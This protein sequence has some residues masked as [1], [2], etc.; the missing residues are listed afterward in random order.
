MVA[1]DPDVGV[2]AI[3]LAQSW[4][5][6]IDARACGVAGVE[7]PGPGVFLPLEVLEWVAVPLAVN[8][9]SDA[10]YELVSRLVARARDNRPNMSEPDRVDQPEQ[11]QQQGASE[12]VDETVVEPEVEVIEHLMGSDRVMVVR[13]RRGM[14]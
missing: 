8:L 11:S 6:D 10:L 2:A 14:R 1:V 7:S 4:N 5:Q 9:A 3:E 13:L 12:S